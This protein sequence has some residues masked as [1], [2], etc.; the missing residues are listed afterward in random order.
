MPRKP[1][2]LSVTQVYHVV[3]KGA[4]RQVMFEESRDYRKY[5]DILDYYH[6]ECHFELYAYCL[7]SNHVHLL[8]HTSDIPISNIF[9]RINTTYAGWFNAKYNR[10][11]F[12]QDGRYYSEPV[13]CDR[14][15]L[16]VLRYIHYNPVKAGLESSPGQKYPWSSYNQFFEPT[17][18]LINSEY[19]LSLFAGISDY[20]EFHKDSPVEDLLDVGNTRKRIPDDVAKEIISDISHC[21]S[22]TEFQNLSLKERKYYIQEIC[23]KGVSIR[24]LNRLT[25]TPKGVIERILNNRL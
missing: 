17:P 4:D 16:T 3:I 18:L 12:L 11:G 25:G 1:R 20:I 10:T 21:C 24:Q 22:S 8:I 2:K 15:L 19:V 9:R 6:E 7:M 23:K 14:Y 13:D 5:L